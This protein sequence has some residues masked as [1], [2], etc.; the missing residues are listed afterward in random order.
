MTKSSYECP[1]II[2]VELTNRCNLE[3]VFCDHRALKSKMT[4]A[5][6]DEG[7]L[8]KILSD[9]KKQFFTEGK[10]IHE[11]GL[12]GLGE[13]TLCRR[14]DRNLSLIARYT[15][16]FDRI[17]INSNLVSLDDDMARLLLNSAIN[18]YTF[19]VNASNRKA[20]LRLS[21]RDLFEKVMANLNHFFRLMKK[22]AKAAN[23]DVQI[24]D[25]GINDVKELRN[26]LSEAKGLDINCFARKIYVKPVLDKSH[27]L[28]NVESVRGKQRYPCWSIYS[29][30]YI[31]VEG[32]FYPCTIGN[33]S[34]RKRSNICLGNVRENSLLY[35]FNSEKIQE[36]RHKAERGG[37][38]FPECRKCNCW[39]ISPNNFKWDETDRGWVK[40]KKLV[41]G[42]G[43]EV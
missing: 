22:K 38:A 26:A 39:L 24:M 30:I 3:C 32:N 19:S 25:S 18:T 33:D 13:P 35:L 16:I 14:L 31:D 42:F 7:L 21:G 5:D 1:W 34:Y 37:L 8:A 4:I 29:R 2:N 43:L 11:L 27:G 9:S 15:D 41:R 12:V 6:M 28:L 10:K 36:A 40:K 17:S 20:Y 23:L